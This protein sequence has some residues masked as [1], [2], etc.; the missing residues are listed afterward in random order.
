MVAL[1]DACLP[2][3]ELTET[4]G[5]QVESFSWGD[6]LNTN[7]SQLIICDTRKFGEKEFSKEKGLQ[8]KLKQLINRLSDLHTP[9]TL[10]IATMNKDMFRVVQAWIKRKDISEKITATY[11]RSDLSRGVTINPKLRYL[12]L[13]SPPHLPDD[14]YLAETYGQTG[15]DAK[16]QTLFK[17][18]DKKSAFINLIGRV[19]DPKGK[20]KSIVYA[21]GITS[22]EARALVTQ[23]HVHAPAYFQILNHGC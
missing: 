2:D 20:E 21:A 9:E 7:R 22:E 8:A 6:P 11:Y 23:E 10:L 19:K 5:V 13:F 14:A 3:L 18:S 4:F 1:V 17:K 16:K 12:I 15:K